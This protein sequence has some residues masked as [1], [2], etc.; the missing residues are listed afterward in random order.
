[1]P[2]FTSLCVSSVVKF[3]IAAISRAV[4]SKYYAVCWC[5]ALLC[6]QLKLLT[7]ATIPGYRRSVLLIFQED[8][9]RSGTEDG[10]EMKVEGSR[11]EVEVR[12]SRLID[13]TASWVSQG[14]EA[15]TS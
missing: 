3:E 1:M 6:V 15:M 12:W 10:S 4:L 7:I 9:G 11:F 14:S 5:G 8:V 13:D 2:F